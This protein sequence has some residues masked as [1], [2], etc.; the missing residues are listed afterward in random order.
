[1]LLDVALHKVD[2]QGGGAGLALPQVC[3]RERRKAA[4]AEQVRGGRFNSSVQFTVCDSES[5][6]EAKRQQGLRP[7][8]GLAVSLNLV[9]SKGGCRAPGQM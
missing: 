6:L 7:A 4:E 2:G 9:D 1:M 3:G 8:A 5:R